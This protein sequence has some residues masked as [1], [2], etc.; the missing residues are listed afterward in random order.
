MLDLSVSTDDV[1]SLLA[2]DLAPTRASELELRQK[3]H[4]SHSLLLLPFEPFQLKSLDVERIPDRSFDVKRHDVEILDIERSL[5][6][7]LTP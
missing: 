5:G 4:L 1:A 6:R 2:N 3:I 7:D